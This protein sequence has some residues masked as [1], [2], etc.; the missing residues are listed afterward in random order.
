MRFYLHT[1][2]DGYDPAQEASLYSL[3]KISEKLGVASKFEY[4]KEPL[5][6]FGGTSEEKLVEEYNASD[7]FVTPT[8]SEGFGLPIIEAMAC[9]LPVVAANVSCLPEHLGDGEDRIIRNIYPRT[10]GWRKRGICT[11]TRQH[12]FAPENVLQVPCPE[13]LADGLLQAAAAEEMLRTTSLADSDIQQM[14]Q[15]CQDYAKGYS[16][17]L[18]KARI[19][20]ALKQASGSIK[21]P[22]EVI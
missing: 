7:F 18:T 11:A 13:S 4:P 15:N 10:G 3:K 22:V 19:C 17:D 21:V 14:H 16:W 9:G 8:L 20:E 1:N 6:L 2:I 5:S 12:I